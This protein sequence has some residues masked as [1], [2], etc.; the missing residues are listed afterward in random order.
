MNWVTL[1]DERAKNTRPNTALYRAALILTGKCNFACPYCKP[2]GERGHTMTLEE[3][4]SRVQLMAERG[5][6]ELRLSGGEPT[7]LPWLPSLVAFSKS[8]G[9]RVAIS[10]NGYANGRVYDALIRAGVDEFSI[11]LDTTD[12]VQADALAG[13]RKNVLQRVYS[14]IRKLSEAGIPVYVGV[15]CCSSRNDPQ[16]IRDTLRTVFEL[17]AADVKIMSVV[18]D[19]TEVDPSLGEENEKFQ[20]LRW[21]TNNFRCGLSIRGLTE[22]DSHKCALV[23]DDVTLVGDQHYPCNVY[24]REGGTSIGTFGT[25]MLAER[26]E[27]F[28]ETDTHKDPICKANCMDLLRAHN[29]RVREIN[30]V[31][32]D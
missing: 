12:P 13:G 21:R 23:L 22:Q 20:F 14:T 27:W 25:N 29:N 10:S 28:R 30:P 7:V 11:S 15:T 8:K 17:G 26:A 5:L 2:L 24:F 19:P 6:Q 4:Q 9:I 18:Q 1:K 3:A 16:E 31:L 32:G